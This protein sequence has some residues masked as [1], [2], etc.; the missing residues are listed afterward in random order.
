MGIVGF[1]VKR[2]DTNVMELTLLSG[3]GW[4]DEGRGA[5]FDAGLK[6]ERMWTPIAARL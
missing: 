3:E 2:T 6:S 1:V 4:L 5:D